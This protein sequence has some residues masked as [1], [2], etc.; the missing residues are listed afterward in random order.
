[1]D[2]GL[3][4]LIRTYRSLE[5]IEI[6]SGGEPQ[7]AFIED[8][9]GSLKIRSTVGATLRWRSYAWGTPETS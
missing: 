6:S 7:L 8:P 3:G 5:N 2:R 9:R 1:M 4:L